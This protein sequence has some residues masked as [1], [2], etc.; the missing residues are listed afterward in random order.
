[1]EQPVSAIGI[2][3]S[4]K[5]IYE[6]LFKFIDDSL[7]SF[8]PLSVDS[9]GRVVTAEDEI[10]EDLA[11]FLDNKQELNSGIFKFRFVNQSK[12]SDIGVKLG[13]GYDSDNR[14]NICWIEAKRLPTPIQNNRDEREYVV[15]GNEKKG[16]GG[17]ERFKENKHAPHLPYSIMIAYI[18]NNTYDFWLKEIN[19]WITELSANDS[20]WNK[21]ELLEPI[22]NCNNRFLSKHQR[23]EKR[24]F[25]E[26]IE[27][28]HFWITLYP[29]NKQYFL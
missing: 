2:P 25:I 12:N 1:M 4:S 14:T 19:K 7:Q 13:R 21:D 23:R 24:R 15:I 27:L 28:R 6:A 26:S 22:S 11:V 5:P 8:T 10:T 3:P 16:K 29:D 20:F 17:I 9:S 18:Q